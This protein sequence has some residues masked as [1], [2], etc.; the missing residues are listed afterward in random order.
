MVLAPQ[1]L[2]ILVEAAEVDPNDGQ[3]NLRKGSA[4]EFRDEAHSEEI[5]GTRE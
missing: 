2:L 3:G 4:M 1:M 5:L